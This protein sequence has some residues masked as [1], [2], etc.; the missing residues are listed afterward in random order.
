M[1]AG[2]LTSPQHDTADQPHAPAAQPAS[3][4]LGF[5][6]PAQLIDAIR[7]GKPASR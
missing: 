4:G 3:R 1:K 5:A 2:A 6:R 7:R